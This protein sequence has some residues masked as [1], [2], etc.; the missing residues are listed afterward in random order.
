MVS[1][2]NLWPD[3]LSVQQKRLSLIVWR[4]VDS[5]GLI[6]IEVSFAHLIF[7]EVCDF[8]KVA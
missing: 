4:R 5:V 1:L 7:D 3:Q 2:P 8:F 6:Q